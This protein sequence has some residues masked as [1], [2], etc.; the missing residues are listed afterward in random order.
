[1]QLFNFDY[2]IPGPRFLEPEFFPSTEQ[3]VINTLSCPP[4]ELL[5]SAH[6]PSVLPVQESVPVTS[7]MLI[8]SALTV[9]YSGNL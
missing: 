8:Y 3:S 9:S 1:M 5:T 4:Q 6:A 7:M 2:V